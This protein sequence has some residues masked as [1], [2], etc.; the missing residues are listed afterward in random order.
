MKDLKRDQ[1]DDSRKHAYFPQRG[2]LARYPASFSLLFVRGA[3]PAAAFKR[4]SPS[5][6][7][8]TE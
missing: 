2:K 5:H 8:I 4:F 6:I 7:L 1:I 3:M